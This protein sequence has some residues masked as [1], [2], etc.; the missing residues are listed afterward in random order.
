MSKSLVLLLLSLT[1]AAGCRHKAII[2]S[3]P[4]GAEVRMDK[5]YL[6][7]TPLEVEVWRVPG[8]KHTLRVTMAGR[9]P[10]TVRI[11]RLKRKS[12]HE[13]IFIRRHGKSGTWEPEDARK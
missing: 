4:A 1:A 8:A 11:N 5:E 6:G 9:R 3:D 10:M 12:E 13:V 7:V 2:T